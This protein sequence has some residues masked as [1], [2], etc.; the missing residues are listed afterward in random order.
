MVS[1]ADRMPSVVV[2]VCVRV[3][4]G[5]VMTLFVNDVGHST[6][7]RPPQSFRYLP[8]CAKFVPR[9]NDQRHRIQFVRTNKLFFVSRATRR[10]TYDYRVFLVELRSLL[11]ECTC[12]C[13]TSWRAIGRIEEYNN[14][15]L[16]LEGTQL[17]LLAIVR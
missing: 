5:R 10:D 11:L 9:V 1:V 4:V 13:G 7:K 14:A 8:T 6:R 2:L 17:D 3:L 16:A 12:L 15:F